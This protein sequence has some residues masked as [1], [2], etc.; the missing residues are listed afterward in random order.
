MDSTDI[1]N[2]YE[3]LVIDYLQTT[4]LPRL[5]DKSTD[6]FLDVACYALTKLPA[7]YMRHEIDMAFYLEPTERR[8]MMDEVEKAVENAVKYIEKNFNRDNRYGDQVD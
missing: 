2:Y 6:F 8:A 3:H 4:V 5:P 1:H 7:R